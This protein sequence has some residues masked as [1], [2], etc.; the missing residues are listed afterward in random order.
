MPKPGT[1]R[2]AKTSASERPAPRRR[3]SD[4]ALTAGPNAASPA[5]AIAREEIA[6]RAHELFL[7]RGGRHGNDWGDWFRAEA[8]LLQEREPDRKPSG[9]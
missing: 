2:K 3:R 5:R 8:E 4:P 9:E 7:A 6:A 1:P